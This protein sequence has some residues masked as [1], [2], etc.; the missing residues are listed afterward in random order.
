MELFSTTEERAARDFEEEKRTGSDRATARQEAPLVPTSMDASW[1]WVLKALE[2]GN[3]AEHAAYWPRLLQEQAGRLRDFLRQEGRRAEIRRR[4]AQGWP[5]PMFQDVVRLFEP[6]AQRFIGEVIG[7]LE[8]RQ[9]IPIES[10][11]ASNRHRR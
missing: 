10:S 6:G 9:S 7:G 8:L 4:V 5:E 11:E 1:R 2:H 3:V